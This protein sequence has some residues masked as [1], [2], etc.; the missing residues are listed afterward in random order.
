MTDRRLQDQRDDTARALERG[1]ADRQWGM[2]IDPDRCTGCIACSAACKAENN[3]PPGVS[4]LVVLEEVRGTAPHTHRRHVPRPCMHCAEPSC[5]S[6]CPVSATF[7]QPDGVVVMDYEKCIG[8]RY[9]MTNCP[10]GARS[11]DFGESYGEAG[12]GEAT[13]ERRPSPE[14]QRA[15]VREEHASPVGNA[16]KC[17]LCLHRTREGLL[18]ACVEACPTGAITFGD[19]ANEHGPVGIAIVEQPT[20]RLREELGN[21]PKV[22]Y[23]S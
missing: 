21:E 5:V 16:R 19:L 18:P 10:Y 14:Y 6:V 11:F 17:H 7:I 12:P 20:V 13:W 23:R 9:C 15:W 4:Y 1:R 8:C 22:Y 3:L 2:V